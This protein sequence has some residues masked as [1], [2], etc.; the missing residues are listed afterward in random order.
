MEA[1]H[2]RIFSI[3]FLLCLS[4]QILYAQIL[5]KAVDRVKSSLSDTLE[6]PGYL[7]YPTIA[8]MPE[9]RFEFGFVG[10]LL[11][12]ANDNKQNRLSEANLFAFV[13]QENQ[14]GIWQEHSLYTDRDKWFIQGATR[15]QFFPL[16][17]FGIGP[18]TQNDPAVVL[19]TNLISRQR[20]MHTV[21]PN[22]FLGPVF[23]INHVYKVSYKPSASNNV[24]PPGATGNTT[25]GLGISMTYDTRNNAL[26]ARDAAYAEI[27]YLNYHL[28]PVFG[29][30]SIQADIRKFMPGFHPNHVW[31]IQGFGSFNYGNIPFNRMALMGGESLMRGYYLGRYRDNHYLA[32]QTEYRILPFSFSK[33]FGASVFAAAGNVANT[34]SNLSQSNIKIAVGGGPRFL[35]FKTKDIFV[36]L[37]A[38]ATNEGM[39]Y[40]FFLGEAF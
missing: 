13:T 1:P 39:A 20:F 5:N 22:L 11:Y 19:S 34:P 28:S 4:C 40:Y 3:L 24:V 33:R 17:Y 26:N 27:T 21:H 23:D 31:A 12:H 8:Y 36:R 16:L 29:F 25:L 9:T 35:V 15:F 6:K 37:D 10:L 38:A 30:Q 32:A 7:F 18:N 2:V 14:W